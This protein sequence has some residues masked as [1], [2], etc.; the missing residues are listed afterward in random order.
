MEKLIIKTGELCGKD[1]S[2]LTPETNFSDDLHMKSATM[3]VLIA[4]L[5]DEIDVDINFMEFR[6]QATIKQAAEYLENL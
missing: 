3:V 6:R 4:Y 2:E 5:E 1:A